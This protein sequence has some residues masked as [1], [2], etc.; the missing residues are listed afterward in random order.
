HVRHRRGDDAAPA[1]R[2]RARDDHVGASALRGGRAQQG[3]LR[4]QQVLLF[5]LL[6]A[7]VQ[8]LLRRRRGL[9]VPQVSRSC[10]RFSASP[11][12]F[13]QAKSTAWP[14]RWPLLQL[15]SRSSYVPPSPAGIF[16]GSTSGS[17]S[18]SR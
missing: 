18:T 8:E 14:T 6:R 7:P 9:I 11:F 3:R 4:A 17:F 5:A 10:L 1:G 2:A 15:R 16:A 13:S 12:S